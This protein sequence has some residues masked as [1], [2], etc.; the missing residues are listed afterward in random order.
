[1]AAGVFIAAVT[2]AAPPEIV[3]YLV[4]VVFNYIILSYD[5]CACLRVCVCACVRVCVC[6]C[7]IVRETERE[8]GS[9]KGLEGSPVI[10]DYAGKLHHDHIYSRQLFPHF[11]NGYSP[12]LVPHFGFF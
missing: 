5:L 8:R 7:V 4:Y 3:E 9:T 1:M 2:P 11:K 6:A 12:A 10:N